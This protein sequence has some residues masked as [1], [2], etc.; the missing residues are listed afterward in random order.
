MTENQS[1][2]LDGGVSTEDQEGDPDW[3][4][5]LRKK[6][7]DYD[8]VT[9][10][11]GQYK[12]QDAVKQAGLDPDNNPSHQLLIDKFGNEI[13]EPDQLKEEAQKY[14]LLGENDNSGSGGNDLS[15]QEQKDKQQFD[16]LSNVQEG[17]DDAAPNPEPEWKKAQTK[18]EFYKK[19]DGQ[20]AS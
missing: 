19:Y 11:L 1:E 4:K 10:E 9:K 17:K 8:K 6:A 20:V 13:P 14:G 16:R 2:E 5:T 7:R 12:R 15:E 3:L 18:E